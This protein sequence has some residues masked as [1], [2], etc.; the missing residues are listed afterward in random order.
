MHHTIMADKVG[1]TLLS[2]N[3][4]AINIKDSGGTIMHVLFEGEEI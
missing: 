2:V 3:V 1:A 4:S